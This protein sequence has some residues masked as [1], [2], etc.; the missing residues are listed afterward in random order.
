MAGANR[1][2]PSGTIV[3]D[4]AGVEVDQ[5]QAGRALDRGEVSVDR[6]RDVAAV[7]VDPH[8]PVV[9][10]LARRP[11]VDLKRDRRRARGL[12]Q[13]R[14]QHDQQIS[15]DPDLGTGGV[16]VRRVE[17]KFLEQVAGGGVDADAP[18]VRP[19]RGQEVGDMLAVL[20][21]RDDCARAARERLQ[22][23]GGDEAQLPIGGGCAARPPG[24]DRD[25]VSRADQALDPAA[26]RERRIVH[27]VAIHAVD[28]LRLPGNR[29]RVELLAFLRVAELMIREPGDAPAG[30]RDEPGAVLPGDHGCGA[31]RH[32][33]DPDPPTARV[34]DTR[35]VHRERRDRRVGRLYRAP[36]RLGRTG[37]R[38]EHQQTRGQEQARQPDPSHERNANRAVLRS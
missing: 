6:E 11:V 3:D 32:V 27:A 24:A 16:R 34:C 33:P 15:A 35:S 21:R 26:V 12:E 22:P 36:R 17:R 8:R 7:V 19:G 1:G 14:R 4:L 2:A 31:G 20:R 13:P 37:L 18:R 38:G 30:D 28:H 29:R 10:E 25:A 5:M 23:G 9:Q